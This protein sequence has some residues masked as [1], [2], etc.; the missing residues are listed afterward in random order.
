MQSQV[1]NRTFDQLISVSITIAYMAEFTE[2]AVLCCDKLFTISV[3]LQYLMFRL[4]FGT[5]WKVIYLMYTLD[6]LVDVLLIHCRCIDYQSTV[7][8]CQQY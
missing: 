8:S 1:K 7:A 2:N 6:I 3:Q 5:I 4:D